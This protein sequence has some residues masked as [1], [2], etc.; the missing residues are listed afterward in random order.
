MKGHLFPLLFYFH[1]VKVEAI[2]EHYGFAD[3]ASLLSIF[4]KTVFFS[5]NIWRQVAQFIAQIPR[6]L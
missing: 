3:K 6:E 2:A 1:I 5:A 4:I